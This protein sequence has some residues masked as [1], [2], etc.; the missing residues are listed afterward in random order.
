MYSYN[1]T[2]LVNAEQILYEC[3]KLEQP[4]ISEFFAAKKIDWKPNSSLLSHMVECGNA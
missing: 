1:G 3:S 2:N 4:S